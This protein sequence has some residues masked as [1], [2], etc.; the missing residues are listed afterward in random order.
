M[1]PCIITIMNYLHASEVDSP[2]QHWKFERVLLDRGEGLGVYALGYW[3]Q[4]PV[5]VFRWNGHPERPK[6]N[7]VSRGYPTWIVLPHQDYPVLVN[8]VE[9]TEREAA[10]HFLRID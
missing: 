2:R 9:G 6:G 4:F 8:I 3:D 5:V 10:K 1:S 7:P